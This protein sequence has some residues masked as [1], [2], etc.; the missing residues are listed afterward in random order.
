MILDQKIKVTIS[1]KNIDHYKNFFP[2]IKLRDNIEI[3]PSI[4][5]SS[6]S[7]IKI[8]VSCDLCDIERYISYQNYYKNLNSC[9]DHK[10]YTCDKCSHIKIKSYNK[11]KYGVEYF[12]KTDEYKTKFKKTMI[13]RYGV[14]YALQSQELKDKAKNAFIKKYGVEN[15]FQSEIIKEE[16]KLS[17]MDKYGVEYTQSL[18]NVKQKR[19][20]TMIKRYGVEYTLQS[21]DLKEKYT[22]TIIQKYGVTHYTHLEEYTEKVKQ[23]N[24]DKYGVEWSFQSENVKNKAKEANLKK[25]GVDNP[26]KAEEVRKGMIITNDPQYIKYI[27][28]SISLFKC[29]AGH[30][31]EIHIDLYHSRKKGQ[32]ISCTIC[33]PIGENRSIKEKELL[34]FIQENY[35]GTIESSYKD[36][37]EIDIYLPELKIGF[38]FN[39]LWWHSEHYKSV[40]YHL[41]KTN[42]F[43]EKGIRIIHIWEDD[44]MYK[45]DIIKSMIL[46]SI[47]HISNKI[48]AR[49]CKVSIIT[50]NSIALNFLENNHIQGN[51]SSIYRIGLFHKDEL[52]SLMTFNKFEGRQK[53][54]EREW[55]LS[56]FCNKRGLIV[57]GGAS[58][59]LSFFTQ[60]M[61]NIERIISYA[62]CDWSV[63]DLYFKLG[64]KKLYDT[65]PDY[66]YVINGVRKHKQNFKKSNLKLNDSITE[67]QHMKNAGYYRVWDCGKMKFEKILK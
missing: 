55:N 25:Y 19:K 54:K 42:F 53:M 31:Y 28:N 12:S 60:K 14:E 66:K 65:K 48:Y 45:R 7:N 34:S 40:N 10:I 36:E 61:S 51:D 11:V 33:N 63:G 27:S 6:G 50:D 16:I 37:L 32:I 38:E 2:N 41:I 47:G 62:D 44:W 21:N 23:T 59:L 52:V 67:C 24:M 57:V 18:D 58:K 1:K 35:S 20:S 64:F 22:K 4:H 56:R 29:D 13:E 26:T 43:K 17:N 5:L 3:D 46:N 15:P 30:E 39:G 9:S 49:Q 8:N